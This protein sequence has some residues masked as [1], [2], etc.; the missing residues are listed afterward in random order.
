MIFNLKKY[1]N[2]LSTLLQ[3]LLCSFIFFRSVF[4]FFLIIHVVFVHFQPIH[5]VHDVLRNVMT[6]NEWFS[7][8]LSV[9]SIQGNGGSGKVT[10]YP[11]HNNSKLQSWDSNWYLCTSEDAFLSYTLRPACSL[12]GFPPLLAPSCPQIDCSLLSMWGLWRKSDSGWPQAPWSYSETLKIRQQMSQVWLLASMLYPVL[13]EKTD[14]IVLKLKTSLHQ[15]TPLKKWKS[16]NRA[17]DSCSKCNPI[18]A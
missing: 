5:P 13:K 3:F 4:K 15:K 9:F 10:K 2:N 18:R 11:I 12:S 7:L 16:K 17:E 14:W 8:F 1:F 6:Y